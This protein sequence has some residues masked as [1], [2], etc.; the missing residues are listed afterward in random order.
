MTFSEVKLEQKVGAPPKPP[1]GT[2]RQAD[3]GGFE[4]IGIP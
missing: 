1:A 4:S 2:L 3:R